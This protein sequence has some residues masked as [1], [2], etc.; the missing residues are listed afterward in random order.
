MRR[1]EK[2][3][4]NKT[5]IESVI[6]K[7]QICRLGLSENGLPYIVPL[8]FGYQD[9]SLYFH[10][11]PEG[12]KVDILKHNNQVCFEFDGDTRITTGKT[13][14][15]WGMQY[16]SVIGYG[17]ASFIQDPKEKRKALDIIMGQYADG[18]FEYSGKALDKT[19]IIKIDISSMTGKKSD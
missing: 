15:A 4:T 9:D 11:A 7:S 14:C 13:A 2:E 5:E 17:E 19:L 10:S 12:R 8:C 18:A 6:R 16:R 1:K 3:I